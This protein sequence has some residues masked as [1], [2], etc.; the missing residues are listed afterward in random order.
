M[1]YILR[2]GAPW[3]DLQGEC[4]PPTTVYNR[5]VRWG[6]RGIWCEIFEA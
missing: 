5:Y 4:R 3:C 2:T 1:F 6:R